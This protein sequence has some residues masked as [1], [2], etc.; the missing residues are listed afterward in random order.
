VGS[1]AAGAPNSRDG[2]LDEVSCGAGIDTVTA[3]AIDKIYV[4]CDQVDKGG[5]GPIVSTMTVGLARGM[6]PVFLRRKYRR[7]FNKRRNFVRKC[8][9]LTTEKVRCR[10]RWNYRRWRYKGKV[11]MR[12]DPKDPNI[13]LAAIDIRRRR[14]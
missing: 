10:V 5:S 9:H 7:A 13:V 11:T 14:R 1:R 2:E 8:S 3:D 6:L 4:E 12:L